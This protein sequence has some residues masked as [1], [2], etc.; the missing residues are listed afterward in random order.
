MIAIIMWPGIWT[1]TVGHCARMETLLAFMWPI[2]ALVFEIHTLSKYGRL[3]DNRKG[4][5]QMDANT[6]C[7][8]TFALSGVLGARYNK[9]ESH[10]FNVAVL[11][12]VAF[13][14]PS[15]SAP[16]NT[17]ESTILESIQKISLVYSTGFLLTGSM[18][19]VCGCK[20]ERPQES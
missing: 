1:S 14:M 11:C 5:L 7:S 6:L 18:F 16:K 3:F 2:A 19:L 20:N 10:V 17:I 15:F 9:E 8:I 13:V 4:L 12:C